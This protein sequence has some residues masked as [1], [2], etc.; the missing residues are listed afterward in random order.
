M[1]SHSLFCKG[2]SY[3]FY[4]EAQNSVAWFDHVVS[5]ST[6]HSNTN[7]IWIDNC[8]VTSDHFPLFIVYNIPNDILKRKPV[9]GKQRSNTFFNVTCLSCQMM[10]GHPTWRLLLR[11][12]LIFL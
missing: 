4:S 3:T 6:F 12:C 10:K 5:A 8:F 9:T 2:D 11:L 1:V 7:D